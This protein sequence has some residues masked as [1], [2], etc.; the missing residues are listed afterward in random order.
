M[1]VLA[2]LA[3]LVAFKFALIALLARAF[4]VFAGRGAARRPG[5]RAGR[6]IRLRAARAGGL[7]GVVDDALGQPLLAAM[8][9]SMIA[10]PFMIGASNRIVL[11]FAS[12][13]WMLRS[14]ADAPGRGAVAR[15]PSAT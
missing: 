8:V 15:R 9:L 13:E 10:T 1:L 7:A 4:G 6:G 11:R 5:A 3:A 2:L 12:S 14:L